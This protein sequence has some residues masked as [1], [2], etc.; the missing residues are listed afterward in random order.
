MAV[1]AA[2]GHEVL[3]TM[4]LL[5]SVNGYSD[6]VVINVDPTTAPTTRSNIPAESEDDARKLGQQ[7]AAV[8]SVNY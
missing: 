7:N 1:L 6:F 2:P 4:P 3:N 8:P 5:Q